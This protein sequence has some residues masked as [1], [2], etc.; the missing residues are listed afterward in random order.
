MVLPSWP[1]YLLMFALLR[2]GTADEAAT[3][4]DGVSRRDGRR[5]AVVSL[6]E[7]LNGGVVVVGA[8]VAREADRRSHA[9]AQPDIGGAVRARAGERVGRGS[10]ATEREADEVRV[11][12]D[13]SGVEQETVGGERARVADGVTGHAGVDRAVA[14]GAG[15]ADLHGDAGAVVL[16]HAVVGDGHGRRAAADVQDGDA[17]SLRGA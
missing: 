8:D 13:R 1:P 9:L 5:S 10:G 7:R 16:H 14:A 4:G 11:A 17:A 6:D 3:G 15:V 12:R 2:T